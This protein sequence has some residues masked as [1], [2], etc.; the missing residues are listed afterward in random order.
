LSFGCKSDGENENGVIA[1]SSVGQF[2][3]SFLQTILATLLTS[4]M[5]AWGVFA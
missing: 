2:E 4:N 3:H 5:D 1:Q